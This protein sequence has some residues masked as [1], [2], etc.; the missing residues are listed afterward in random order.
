MTI[1]KDQV[2]QRRE[3]ASGIAEKITALGSI[4]AVKD[5]GVFDELM[6]LI[7]RGEI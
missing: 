1:Q 2:E 3:N 6:G 4:D 7:D 5:S